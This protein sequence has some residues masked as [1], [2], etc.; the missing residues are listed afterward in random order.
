MKKKKSPNIHPGEILLEEF[1]KPY[2][3]SQYRLAKEIGVHPRRIS[4]IVRCKRAISP[5][6]AIR[7]AR[8]FCTDAY[9]WLNLQNHYDVWVERDKMGESL[10]DQVCVLKDAARHMADVPDFLQ[11]KGEVTIPRND[12]EWVGR[13]L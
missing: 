13:P 11:Y 12:D 1:M 10:K 8:Y 7:L 3:V 9:Y 6:T 2:G 4:E 5:N